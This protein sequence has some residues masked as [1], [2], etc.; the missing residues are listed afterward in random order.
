MVSGFVLQS[1]TVACYKKHKTCLCVFCTSCQTHGTHAWCA[2]LIPRPCILGIMIPLIFDHWVCGIFSPDL[3]QCLHCFFT[4]GNIAR[5]KSTI[6]EIL[7]SNH[8]SGEVVLEEYH[9]HSYRCGTNQHYITHYT[10]L[11]L[12]TAKHRV[13]VFQFHVLDSCNKLHVDIIDSSHEIFER[14]VIFD[15]HL[16]SEYGNSCPKIVLAVKGTGDKIAFFVQDVDIRG[17]FLRPALPFC[18]NRFCPRRL[19]SQVKPMHDCLSEIGASIVKVHF[20]LR[21]VF[22]LTVDGCMWGIGQSNGFGL[23]HGLFYLR[24]VRLGVPGSRYVD[25]YAKNDTVVALTQDGVLHGCGSNSSNTLAMMPCVLTQTKLFLAL[26]CPLHVPDQGHDLSTWQRDHG[27]DLLY[28]KVQGHV[29]G[30]SMKAYL[31]VSLV[32]RKGVPSLHIVGDGSVMFLPFI[33]DK[34]VV[35]NDAGHYRRLRPKR[36]RDMNGKFHE[37]D[38]GQEFSEY[39]LVSAR[40]IVFGDADAPGFVFP[41]HP[42]MFSY[43]LMCTFFDACAGRLHRAIL[44]SEK[45]VAVVHRQEL[46]PHCP[47]YAGQSLCLLRKFIADDAVGFRKS[48]LK[49]RVES[50]IALYR[51][52]RAVWR[53]SEARDKNALR[54]GLVE[55]P[56]FPLF[57]FLATIHDNSSSALA[58]NCVF[59]SMLSLMKNEGKHA[60]LPCMIFAQSPCLMSLV[61]GYDSSLFAQN[62]VLLRLLRR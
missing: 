48:V 58:L 20:G 5:R 6:L 1:L 62:E 10:L 35:G 3:L 37:L 54:G 42:G 53:D 51:Q 17:M 11:V 59:I 15:V 49:Q 2:R 41:N 38:L 30:V 46:L 19:L 9:S 14:G 32:V 8:V 39:R 52:Q 4:F 24:F 33:R 55:R 45:D 26:F 21:S 57:S 47:F 18:V 12:E 60:A 50:S 25:M 61:V 29:V 27:D 43:K 36:Y 22:V 34:S 28:S 23:V 40:I 7:A 31:L 16:M 13:W 56:R 44:G